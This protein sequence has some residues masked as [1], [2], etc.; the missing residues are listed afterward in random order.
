MSRSAFISLVIVISA[1]QLFAQDWSQWR[2]ANRDGKAGGFTAP[3]S[4]PKELTQKWKKTVGLGDATP[5]LVDGKLYTFGRQDANEVVLCLDSATGQTLWEQIYP[6]MHEV[7]GPAARHPGP[8]SSVAVTDGKV[9]SLGVGGILS[10]IDTANGNVLWRKQSVEDYLGTDYKFDASMSPIVVNGLCVV[11]VGGEGKGALIAFNLNDGKAK[12]KYEG[13]APSNSSPV[14]M[15]VDGTGQIVTLSE[16]KLIGVSLADGTLL[17]EVPFEAERGNN[18]TPVIDGQTLYLVGI[19]KGV[20]AMKVEKQDD[21]FAA[22]EIWSNDS[23]Q[24]GARFTTPVLKDGMLFGFNDKLY[25]LNAQTGEML[26]IDTVSG[27][28]S[29]AIIDIG[30]A[31]MALTLKGE[32][33]V[34]EP[35]GKQ[36]TELARY[37]VSETETWAHPVITDKSIFIRDKDS[38]TL[39]SIE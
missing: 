36:Y 39:W 18:T 21:K 9:C 12:W 10:C 8:R 30:S 31:M 15:T 13:E 32:L 6:A 37:K 29:A 20:V 28:Q 14:L 22:N 17:W 5:A 26:W 27:G 23:A 35:T 24:I 19:G 16:K 11:Y 3:K 34:Y 25:C 38:V 2:G 4:W 7:T 1:A 33:V